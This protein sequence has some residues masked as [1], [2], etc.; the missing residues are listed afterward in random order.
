MQTL[1]TARFDFDMY[2]LGARPPR[3]ASTTGE[4]SGNANSST[5]HGSHTYRQLQRG[6]HAVI[7]ARRISEEEMGRGESLIPDA[8]SQSLVSGSACSTPLAT[9]GRGRADSTAKDIASSASN[10]GSWDRRQQIS[11][12]D[13]LHTPTTVPYQDVPFT[14]TNTHPVVSKLRP[15]CRKLRVEYP[16]STVVYVGK[17]AE[18]S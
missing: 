13:I 15:V 7:N 6:G 14:S 2:G 9:A 18:N 10:P 12:P 5:T 4:G 8:E 1:P 3:Q 17:E 11:S 16:V